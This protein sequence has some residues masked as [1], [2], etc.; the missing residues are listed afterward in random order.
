MDFEFKQL[1]GV[2]LIEE[3]FNRE[4]EDDEDDDTDG[5][6][7]TLNEEEFDDIRSTIGTPAEG[8]TPKPE[9]LKNKMSERIRVI[10]NC[11]Q[12]N[13]ILKKQPIGSAARECLVER[14][15]FVG[16][17]DPMH[18]PPAPEDGSEPEPIDEELKNREFKYYEVFASVQKAKIEELA[19]HLSEFK[20]EKDRAQKALK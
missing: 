12:I 8:E 16:P 18:I 3:Q 9:K 11:V 4:I 5:Q 15:K 19:T 6:P 1:N 17:N 2:F 7:V 10:E 20:S 13:R 14:V